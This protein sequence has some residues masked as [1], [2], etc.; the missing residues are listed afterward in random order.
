MYYHN[1]RRLSKNGWMVRKTKIHKGF[2]MEFVGV[3]QEDI[4]VQKGNLNWDLKL[5]EMIK[6]YS[7]RFR[8]RVCSDP[9]IK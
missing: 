5:V 3:I 9:R 4:S 1:A 7:P 8:S 6:K 2:V